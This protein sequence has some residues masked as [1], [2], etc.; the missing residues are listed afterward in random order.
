MKKTTELSDAITA[1]ITNVRN[2]AD[3]LQTVVAVLA[4]H[5]ANDGVQGQIA[6]QAED[7]APK[8][9]GE[10]KKVYALEDVRAV[11]A[12]KSQSGLTLEVKELLGNFGASK[13]SDID[14]KSYEELIKAAE[15]LG[16]E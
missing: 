15:V 7:K 13:L 3:S 1:V 14:P 5:K 2:L 6:V 4:I 10:K 8:A 16:N 11:L 12:E 9:K